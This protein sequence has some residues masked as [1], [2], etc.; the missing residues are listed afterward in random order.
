MFGD[1]DVPLQ[2]GDDGLGK[3]LF[4][5]RDCARLTKDQGESCLRQEQLMAGLGRRDPQDFA[6][7][8][9]QQGLRPM[10]EM[11]NLRQCAL[12]AL[13]RGPTQ[14]LRG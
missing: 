2:A 6:H 3:C 11:A 5:Q 8:R 12:D 1:S 7:M 14:K 9:T 10:N 13:S 4:V